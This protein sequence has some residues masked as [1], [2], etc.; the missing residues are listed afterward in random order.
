MNCVFAVCVMKKKV[1]EKQEDENKVQTE[2]Q[3][4]V[5]LLAAI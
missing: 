1:E 4:H 2:V 3:S 5:D